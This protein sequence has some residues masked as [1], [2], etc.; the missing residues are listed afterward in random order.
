[1]QIPY[2]SA[3][4]SLNCQ[5]MA[6]T[7]RPK[8]ASSA[9]DGER[10]ISVFNNLESADGAEFQTLTK[11]KSK[12]EPDSACRMRYDQCAYESII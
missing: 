11:K 5:R 9:A 2:T 8:L 12:R 10:L 1:M 7:T 3:I 4:T 6:G